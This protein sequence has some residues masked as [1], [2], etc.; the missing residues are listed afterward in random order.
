MIRDIS[1]AW[2]GIRTDLQRFTRAAADVS[3]AT[4]SEPAGAATP[5]VPYT[6]PPSSLPADA[7]DLE[8]AL[9]RM[10][11]AQ[12]A[13]SAQLHAEKSAN[14]VASEAAKL[15]QPSKPVPMTHETA[16]PVSAAPAQPQSPADSPA[17]AAQ[18][19]N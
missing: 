13:F 1:S 16:G 2:Q 15:A 7:L 5:A 3:R 10:H 12:R 11:Q 17:H 19:G 8:E 18:P 9:V 14:A 6:P 4:L